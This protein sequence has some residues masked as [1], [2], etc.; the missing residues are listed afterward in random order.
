MFTFKIVYRKCEY[1]KGAITCDI[2]RNDDKVVRSGMKPE[3]AEVDCKLLN[4]YSKEGWSA[5]KYH[6]E[7]KIRIQKALD[8]YLKLVYYG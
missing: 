3:F 5:E 7:R 4:E 6:E 8:D 1:P 2:V